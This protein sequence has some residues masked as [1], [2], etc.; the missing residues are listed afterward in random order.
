MRVE[1]VTHCLED[2]GDWKYRNHLKINAKKSEVMLTGSRQQ[3]GK[4]LTSS[5]AV[6]DS[7]VK[8]KKNC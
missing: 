5:L 7:T 3:L 4:C 6:L 2:I 1:K 8:C